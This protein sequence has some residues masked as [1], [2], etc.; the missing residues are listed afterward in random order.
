MFHTFVCS[1]T[2]YDIC[3]DIKSDEGDFTDEQVALLNERSPIFYGVTSVNCSPFWRTGN[4][5]L[6]ATPN[7]GIPCDPDEKLRRSYELYPSKYGDR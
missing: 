1:G 3:F 4:I 5:Y 7:G 2:F 6:V